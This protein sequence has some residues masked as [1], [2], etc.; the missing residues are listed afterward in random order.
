MKPPQIIRHDQNSGLALIE[1]PA[2]RVI[3]Q[4]GSFTTLNHLG[5]EAGATVTL[6]A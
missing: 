1:S 2:I 4:K 3:K 5:R 6:L